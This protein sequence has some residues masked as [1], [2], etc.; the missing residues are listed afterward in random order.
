MLIFRA[1]IIAIGALA[2]PAVAAAQTSTANLVATVDRVLE[3]ERARQAP[4]AT[5]ADIDKLLALMSDSV[6][7]EHPRAR[8]RIQGKAVMR[9]GMGNFL[10]TV[11]NARDSVVQRTVAPGVVVLV[12]QSSAEISNNGKWEPM[13]R[14][15]IRVFE[16]D[17]DLI[18]RIIEYGW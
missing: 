6:V 17:G 5:V 1:L 13:N 8:A 9:Q 16:F 2:L 12:T 15:A 14:R 10:G 4:G 3:L 7:Y 11:R 18:R